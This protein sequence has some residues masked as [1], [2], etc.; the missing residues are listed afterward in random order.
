LEEK[1]LNIKIWREYVVCKRKSISNIFND[2]QI[3][4]EELSLYDVPDPEAPYLDNY[5]LIDRINYFAL[6]FNAYNKDEFKP[7][8]WKESF[9]GEKDYIEDE[10]LKHGKYKDSLKHLRAILFYCQRAEHMG[11]PT[12][13]YDDRM[14]KIIFDIRKLLK[15]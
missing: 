4:N 13:D 9:Y 10:Y 12:K 5:E 14:K 8:I 15:K 11:G 3:S 2:F 1:N 6:T 7:E